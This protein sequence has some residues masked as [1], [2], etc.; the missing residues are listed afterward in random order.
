M[1]TE[2]T[3]NKGKQYGE[4]RDLRAGYAD[5]LSY[6]ARSTLFRRAISESI[7]R[8]GRTAAAIIGLYMELG[9]PTSATHR[10]ADSS[11]PLLCRLTFSWILSGMAA[12]QTAS[13]DIAIPAISAPIAVP[14]S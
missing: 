8:K 10:R 11:N 7:R 12:A 1:T 4:D 3:K 2:F 14:R 5:S 13:A 9:G 6:R